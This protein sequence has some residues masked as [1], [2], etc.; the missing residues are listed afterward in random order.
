MT[1]ATANLRKGKARLDLLAY[2]RSVYPTCHLCGYPIDANRC[3]R[4]DPLGSTVD[5]LTPLSKGGSATDPANCRHAHRACNSIRG[6]R[7]ITPAI[8][9]A[10]VDR[11]KQL[12]GITTRANT[13]R[14]R[15]W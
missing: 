15:N 8:H 14:I 9:Q 13:I 10:C 2:I 12:L 3:A 4:T 5:E 1:H 11:I 6:N 7:D